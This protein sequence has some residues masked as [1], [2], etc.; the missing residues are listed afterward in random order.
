M[1]CPKSVISARSLHCLEQFRYWKQSGQGS[2]LS[3][4]VKTAEAIL[5]LEQ[6]WRMENE[7][8][9]I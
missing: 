6:V 1:Q 3:M 2:L 7:R 8:G 5:V 4:D 9:E